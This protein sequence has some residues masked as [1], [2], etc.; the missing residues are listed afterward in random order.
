MSLLPLLSTIPNLV[1]SHKVSIYLS[2]DPATPNYIEKSLALRTNLAWV[3]HHLF[4]LLP[5]WLEAVTV[6]EFKIFEE[7]RK[8]IEEEKRKKVGFFFVDF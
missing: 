6:G 8:E 4:V 5:K 2:T 7:R 3:E 1:P